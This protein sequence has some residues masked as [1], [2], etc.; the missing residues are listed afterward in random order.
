M[1]P[2]GFAMRRGLIPADRTSQSSMEAS[3]SEQLHESQSEQPGI[4]HFI[5][6]QVRSI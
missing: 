5:S 6:S 3:C 4:F 2:A 1:K